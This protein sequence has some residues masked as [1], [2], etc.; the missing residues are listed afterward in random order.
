MSISMYLRPLFLSA[1]CLSMTSSTAPMCLSQALGPFGEEVVM[2]DNNGII[3]APV[4]VETDIFG[5]LGIVSNSC[6]D[7]FKT[8]RLRVWAKN[9]PISYPKISELTDSE[10]K[11]ANYGLTLS[12]IPWCTTYEHCVS[13]I[14]KSDFTE[15]YT[16]ARPSGGD[17]APYRLTDFEGYDHNAMPPIY[18]SDKRSLTQGLYDATNALIYDTDR[19][20]DVY[21]GIRGSYLH[22]YEIKL[23][24]LDWRNGYNSG[25]LHQK[26]SECY[27]G[28]ILK[29]TNG[30]FESIIS[31]DTVGKL[32]VSDY[33]MPFRI[34]DYRC[35]GTY[36][37][38][39]F[40]C[41]S[42]TLPSANESGYRVT[43]CL[44]LTMAISNITI[45]ELTANI[46]MTVY[47]TRS[48]S[49]NG[50]RITISS[51]SFNNTGA[52]SGLIDKLELTF[53]GSNMTT[54][55]QR[56]ILRNSVSV[57]VGSSTVNSFNNPDM[58]TTSTSS[59]YGGMT[60]AA[61]NGTKQ[62][63]INT[64]SFSGSVAASGSF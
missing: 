21:V 49:G 33:E 9:K 47:W 53:T 15:Y 44:P 17:S 23:E 5:V 45:L 19:Y 34:N 16:Y 22:P 36:K 3:T 56:N 28:V 18:A 32:A 50:Y 59:I 4:N 35:H 37:M 43:N 14:D 29:G 40:L 38:M 64:T 57:P 46:T 27:L 42:S 31:N 20:V 61:Y 60:L 10:R 26:A 7:A 54:V 52:V 39:P 62:I 11:S 58:Y 48:N 12:S 6:L 25:N 63:C 51:I 1:I 24:D 13:Y 2:I 30:T 41:A 55:Q 8:D